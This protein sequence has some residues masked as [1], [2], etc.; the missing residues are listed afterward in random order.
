MTTTSGTRFEQLL[1]SR[2]A[3]GRPGTRAGGPPAPSGQGPIYEFGGG[4]PDPASFP[5]QGIVAATAEM[6]EVE[7]ADALTYGDP[8]GYAGL[9][10]FVCRKYERFEGLNLDPEGVL[11]TNGSGHA[12]SLVISAFVDVGDPVICE[13]PTFLGTLNTLRRHGAEV[14]DAPIDGEGIVTGAVR[15]RLDGLRER[16]RRCKLIYTMPNFHNPG[17]PTMS[18]ARRRELLALAREYETP[19]L[20]D[21]AY[22]EL[23]FEG[24]ALPSLYALDEQGGVI[25][26][27]TL[28]KILGAGM[29]LGWLV[30]PRELMPVFQGFNFGGGVNPFASRV[31]TYYMR[32]YLEEHVAHLVEVYREKRDAMVRGLEEGLAGVAAEISKPEGGFFLWLKLPPGADRAQVA[33]RA[34]ESRVQYV[35]GTACFAN[36]GGE[37]FIRLAYSYESPERCYEGARLLGEAIRGATA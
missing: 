1:S 16:G 7:G 9:R 26:T 3:L 6:M 27:G 31:A 35:P 37:E 19:I 28:S 23:R 36:G 12:I 24:E 8:Q 22:G 13:A 34:A 32:E 21:D 4:R 33:Q 20:E 2:A 14:L 25:R 15:E 11:I 5:Y 29:R 10:D 30:A 18:L 17:G